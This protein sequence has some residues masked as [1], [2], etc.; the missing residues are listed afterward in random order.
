MRDNKAI[1]TAA[2]VVALG[3]ALGLLVSLSSGFGPRTDRAVPEALGRALARQTLKLL[4]PGGKVTVITRDTGTFQ[5]PASDFQLSAFRQ[6]LGNAGVAIGSVQALQI[7]PLRPSM[8]P[9]GDFL[10]WIKQGAKGDVLVSFMG[11]PML[12]ETQLGRLG[13]IKPSIV[14]FCS[15]PVLSQTDLVGLF[16]HGLLQAA[17]VSRRSGV[18]QNRNGMN[19]QELFNRQFAEVTPENVA[20]FSTAS[21]P[22]P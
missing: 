19:E 13:E 3:S 16:A 1:A 18:A 4:K 7:D 5:N 21:N 8:A 15:G 10:Q 9:P 11:P 14:A 6:A 12:N 22:L 2:G 17:I 20:A